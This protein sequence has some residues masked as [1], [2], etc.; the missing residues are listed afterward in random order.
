MTEP[1]PPTMV[2]LAEALGISRQGAYDWK[3]EGMP[4]TSIEAAL[5]WQAKH[6]ADDAPIHEQLN[7]LACAS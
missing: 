2:S 1:N 5:A 6:K 3:G 4:V 7:L